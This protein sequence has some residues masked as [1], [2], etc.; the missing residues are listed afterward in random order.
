MEC[1]THQPM[2][3]R[4]LRKC[5]TLV[6]AINTQYMYMHMGCIFMYIYM[7]IIQKYKKL[8]TLRVWTNYKIV[9]FPINV[10]DMNYI[11]T[12]KKTLTYHLE[13]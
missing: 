10:H 12:P 7:C 6:P 4:Q 1:I 9:K 8:T 11:R 13:T 3:L 2:K 5:R